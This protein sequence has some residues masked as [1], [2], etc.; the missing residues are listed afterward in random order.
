MMRAPSFT[1]YRPSAKPTKTAKGAADF[2]HS[3]DKMAAILP[4]VKRLVALQKDCV[5]ILPSMFNACEVSLSEAGQLVLS[6]PN[7]AL[8]TKLKQQLPKLQE[9]LLKRGWQVSAIR[10]KVQVSQHVERD[11][12]PKQLTLPSKAQSALAALEGSLDNAPRNQALKAAISAM[13]GRHRQG[14]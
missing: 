12:A 13:L 6:I 11:I 7:A 10:L 8:A 3:D 5:A 14:K 1:P 2:L 9:G 4:T